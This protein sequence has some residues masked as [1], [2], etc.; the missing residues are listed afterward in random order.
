MVEAEEAL[1]DAFRTDVRP[2]LREYRRRKN[3]PEDPIKVFR[4]GNYMEK[5]R[6]ERR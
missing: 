6:R 5:R 2:L 4:E 3:L 1:M